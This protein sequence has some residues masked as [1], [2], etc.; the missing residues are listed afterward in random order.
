MFLARLQIFEAKQHDYR[1]HRIRDRNQ[2]GFKDF[3]L[4]TLPVTTFLPLVDN[5]AKTG[6]DKAVGAAT[7]EGPCGPFRAR[8]NV[9]LPESDET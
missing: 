1:A 5:W 7:C 6:I 2:G 9:R 3:A 8:E 4:G